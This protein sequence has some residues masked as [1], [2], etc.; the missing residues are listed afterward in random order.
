MQDDLIANVE[1]AA[2]FLSA[3]FDEADTILFRP[4]ETWI[5]ADRKRSRVD[6]KSTFYRKAVPALVQVTVLQLLRRAAQERLNLFFGVCPRFGPKGRFDLAWQ[7]R[8]VRALWTDIDHVTLDEARERIAKAGLPPPS[9][10]VN[11]G[12]GVHLYWL[13][14]SPYLI[15]DAG[16]PPPV[17][18]EWTKTPDGRK[19]PRKYIVENGE[20]VYLDQRRHVSRLSPKAEH[21]QDVLAGIAKAIGGDHT[22]DP[23]RLLRLPGTL[24]R[25]DERN[26]RKPVPTELVECD[27]ERKYPLATFEPLKSA[28]LETERAKKI[29]AM[30]LPKARKISVSKADKLAEL[31]AAS[32]VAPAGSRSEADFSLCCFAIRNGIAK[33]EV[34]AQVQQVGKFAEGGQRYFDRTWE[35][36][37]YDARAA[38]FD[39]LQKCAAP[40]TPKGPTVV[41]DAAANGDGDVPS[42][43]DEDEDGRPTIT[44][45]PATMPVADTL[46]QV[47]DKLLAAGNCFNRADQL[48]VIYDQQIVAVLSSPEL[49]GLL[50]QHVEF[51]FVDEEAGQYKPFPPSYANTW[52]N[53]HVERGRFQV[54][55]LF[56]HNPV[57]TD[58]WRL[59]VPGFDA[60]SGIYYAGPA[61][62][63]RSDTEH[64][65][66]L[67]RDFCFKKPA[68]RT[69]YLGMLLTA[70]L[71]PR[72]IGSKPAALFNGNQ[73][74]LGKSILAQI[75][76]I[77]RDGQVAETA[78]YNPND[79]EFEKRLGAIVRRGD[80]TIIV[81]NAKSRGRNPRIESAC[82]ERSITD[83]ILSFRLLGQSASIRAENSHI[84]CITAN[85]PDV[86]RDLVTRSVVINL[87][88]E[89][90]PER[91]EFS[92]ADPE[93]YAREH[94]LELLGELI[95]M[96][97]RWKAAGMP[98]AKV[99]SR[100]NKRSWGNIVG[101]ILAASGEPDFLAN[102]E[103]AATL[104]D[105]TRRDFTELVGALV[106][107]PQGNW[108]AAE[109]V[110]LCG[111]QGLLKDDLGD[112]SARSLATK[113]GTIAGRFVGETFALIDG[114]SA[115]FSRTPERKGSIYRV[116]VPESAE[117]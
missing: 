45:D 61:V 59:V 70:L 105:E 19:K 44:V 57:Y 88:Y 12:N 51:F 47:T 65:D 14:D 111:K 100:F 101:G 5:E 94:R 31:I 64:V 21:L 39:K 95:G 29:A 74:E 117:P 22:T 46:H 24:N 80:T 110:N 96:V 27:P 8:T 103:E 66:L 6:Y 52:L 85:T 17:E 63:A 73:P 32:G 3:L 79:E 75:I 34:W 50:N 28:S 106:E 40:K 33:E 30:P 92:I 109:M 71:V 13:L 42:D 84:F 115:V 1:P 93:G 58:D 54:I 16:D 89:G 55:K 62:E 48:V 97:E 68:D 26:G 82:L 67:L 18:T 99:N 11:S 38:T 87:Y 112:G 15:D 43:T 116:A 37:E 2:R 9:V 56:T 7:I 78:S 60:Q 86:S 102:A 35:A 69:N 81:D 98:M 104:L 72:F 108:T 20:K 114:R 4:I 90:D 36:S 83:P 77:L 23:S 91:R 41:E 49:A 53:H 76:A 25:K 113:M 10:I 107:H